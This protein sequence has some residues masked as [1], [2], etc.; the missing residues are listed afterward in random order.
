MMNPHQDLI[1]QMEYTITIVEV[2]KKEI[3][4]KRNREEGQ[5]HHKNTVIVPLLLRL[6][7]YDMIILLSVV[8]GRSGQINYQQKQF[9]TIDIST[10]TECYN[11]LRR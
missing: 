10:T 7:L 6:K 9:L 4:I 3:P 11:I 8:K 5:I 1:M 2:Y